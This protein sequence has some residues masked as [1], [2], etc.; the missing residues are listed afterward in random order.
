MRRAAQVL[1]CNEARL[2]KRLAFLQ[3]IGLSDSEAAI[4][5]SRCPQV[6]MLSVENNIWPKFDYL[7]QHMG[8]SAQSIVACPV[9]LTLSLNK[10]YALQAFAWHGLTVSVL[11]MA[12]QRCGS[13]L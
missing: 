8:G 13:V 1:A 10:R 6:L 7:T 2:R 11:I 3:R 12:F 9:Y 4:V 5:I